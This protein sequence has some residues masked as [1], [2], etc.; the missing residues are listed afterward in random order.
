MADA[1]G[2]GVAAVSCAVPRPTHVLETVLYATDMDAMR[3]FY[4]DAVGLELLRD[5][6]ESGLVFRVSAQ[7]VLLVFDPRLAARPGRGVPAHGAAGPG[8]VAFSIPA[9]AY[10]DWI[11][12]LSARGVPIEQEQ[13]W[14]PDKGWRAGRSIYV[15]DPAGNSVEFVTADIWAEAGG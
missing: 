2:P 5:W 12:H 8:H 11:D 1:V 7:S 9:D 4:R 14:E 10:Q 13:R 6:G 3:A 15:R